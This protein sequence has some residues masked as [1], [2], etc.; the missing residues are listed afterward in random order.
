MTRIVLSLATIAFLIAFTG[1][2]KND[3]S[4][5]RNS[6]TGT[7]ASLRPASHLEVDCNITR[8]NPGPVTF[9]GPMDFAYN[10]HGDPLSITQVGGTYTGVPNYTFSYDRKHRLTEMLAS[11]LNGSYEINEK[12]TLRGGITNLFDKEPLVV[13]GTAGN[14]NAGIYDIIGRSFFIAIK[15]RM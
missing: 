12:I 11:Y 14:T 1:C 9:P 8:I 3:T 4:P 5:D 6:G 10:A 15:A 13:G 7:E 2:K